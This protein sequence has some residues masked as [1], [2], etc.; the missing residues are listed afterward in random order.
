MKDEDA[1]ARRR[2]HWVNQITRH[3]HEK[4]G[5]VYLRFEGRSMPLVTARAAS[6]PRRRP[7]WPGAASA[8]ETGGHA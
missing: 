5:A 1:P 3:A 4:P 2:N 6:E 8:P 7:R